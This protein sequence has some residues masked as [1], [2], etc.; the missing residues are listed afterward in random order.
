LCLLTLI[1]GLITKS[2]ILFKKMSFKK[3]FN[4]MNS[5]SF[6]YLTSLLFIALLVFTTSCTKDNNDPDNPNQ[7]VTSMDSL[8]APENFNFEM[9]SDVNIQVFAKDNQDGP[10][11]GARINIYA[12]DSLEGAVLLLSG[13][14]NENG[15]F[16]TQYPLSKNITNIIVTTGY[17]G[18]PSETFVT[19]EGGGINTVLGGKKPQPTF[20]EFPGF[21][22]L[23]VTYPYLCAYDANG[24]PACLNP[25]DDVIGNGLLADINAALPEFAP[26]P[27]YHPEYLASGNETDIILNEDA[28]VWMTFVHEGAGNKN[29]LGFY[30]YNVNNPPTSVA[31][32]EVVTIVFPNLSLEFSGGGLHPGNKMNLGQF[33]AGTGIGW[34]LFQNAF[35]IGGSV[36]TT[37]P[38][39]YSDPA[40]NPE[41]DP[42]K[43]QHNVI[44]YDGERQ[45]FVIGFEDLNRTSGGDNDFNDAIYYITS[46]PVTAI[47]SAAMPLVDP[48]IIDT[49][50]DGVYDVI[51]DF[52]NDPSR[53]F[54]NYYPGEDQK[55]SFAFEDL[56]P[57]KG[58]YDFNDLVLEYNIN[59]VTNAENKVVD[60][61]SEYTIKA[62]G[63]G[64]KNGFGYQLNLPPSA[65]ANVSGY[66]L[67]ED[68]ITLSGNGT[69]SGQNKATIIVFDNTYN[70]FPTI[71][72]GF[73]NTRTEQPY[74]TPPSITVTVNLATPQTL[75][76]VGLPPYNPFLIVNKERGKEVHLPGYAP[77]A[78]VNQIYFGTEDDDSNPA[79][80]RYYKSGSNLPWG[81]HL[82]VSFDYPIEKTPILEG[83]LVFDTWVLSGGFSYMD[84]Y[85]NKPGF[86][87]VSFLYQH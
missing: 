37:K 46:N 51:D 21:K 64:Y 49:D 69:E 70:L 32:I 84:W 27:Q 58:D 68:F 43:K 87:E 74:V 79:Q 78:L 31:Q 39:F 28:D 15:A 2:E 12:G 66:S 71:A 55:G 60:I 38:K 86:R 59:Q 62:I 50:D 76:A 16:E 54:N 85:E 63:A 56:W 9:V 19:V 17:I 45:L 30:T 35:T 22:S 83:H 81:M 18:L 61:I 33:P 48:T 40:F 4:I 72:S 65:I 8:V 34:V 20:K 67:E 44:L 1:I 42:A 26:V 25:P 75:A 36:N 24:V 11:K 53:A 6:F 14:T 52:P 82:P 57:S 77:T 5:K 7:N 13:M 10:I 23:D 47:Q 29:A 41:V 80:G 3:N 73:V